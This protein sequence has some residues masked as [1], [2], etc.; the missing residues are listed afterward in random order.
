MT[1]KIV[2]AKNNDYTLMKNG[3][4]LYSKYRPIQD[5]ENFIEKEFNDE[6]DS[7]ILIGLG[8]GYHLLALVKRVNSLKQITVYSPYEEE[9]KIYSKSSVYSEI[10]KYKNISI[11]TD[12]AEMS[13]S[14]LD[15]LII[16]RVWLQIMDRGNPLFEHLN[17][18]KIKQLSYK[19]FQTL[20][21]ENFIHNIALKE[22]NLKEYKVNLKKKVACLVSSG[23][24]LQETKNWLYPIQNKVYIV[25]VGSALKVLINSG[26]KPDAVIISDAQREIVNQL[27]NSDYNGMLFYLSTANKEAI[28]SYPF[29]RCILL[30]NGYK[31]A[32]ETSKNIGYPLLDTGGSVATTAFSLIEYLG[33][34]NIVF[35]GQ[36]LGFANQYTHV[37]GSTSM[38]EI[39]ANEKLVPIIS[40]EQKQIYTLPNL[41][42]YLRWFEKKI[43]HTTVNVYNTAKQGA[44]I[45]GTEFITE[46]EFLNLIIKE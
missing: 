33:F 16:P 46:Q 40:N 8:L 25:C 27:E 44:K 12:I 35:F 21:E 14:L 9:L 37:K 32:E 18:I 22:F 26:I 5:A 29:E 39:N 23:P 3:L 10:Q 1:Y 41:Y 4:Y 42:S 13:I 30:Q 6:A 43:E 20:M 34:Y 24:S 31:K 45:K 17:D 19:R 15:Q 36:D 28:Y 7:Y 2:K 38:R 11:V